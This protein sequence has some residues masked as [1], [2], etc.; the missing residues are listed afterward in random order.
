V[1]DEADVSGEAWRESRRYPS[2]AYLLSRVFYEGT[3]HCAAIL[4]GDWNF[5]MI[6]LEGSKIIDS[7]LPVLLDPSHR[8]PDRPSEPRNQVQATPGEGCLRCGGLLILS[9]TAAFERDNAGSPIRLR[10]CVNCGDC[11]DSDIL[12]NRWKG[13]GLVRPRTRL[14]MVPQQAG[15]RGRPRG[16]GLGTTR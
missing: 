16:T 5:A 9:Y 12:A 11:T 13:S 8:A 14:R 2:H 6:M 15:R 3:G 4:P 10:R 1:G 7:S